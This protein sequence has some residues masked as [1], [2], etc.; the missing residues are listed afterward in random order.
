MLHQRGG[1]IQVIVDCPENLIVDSDRLRLKQTILN[2]GRNSAKFVEEGF[3]RLRALVVD[4]HVQL[5]VEDSGCGIPQEKRGRLFQKYQ[6]SLDLLSQ[7]TVREDC[8][9]V[10]FV[11]S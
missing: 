7:G 4:D 10:E 2:L 8:S 5:Y 6:E 11:L 3:I 1:K 9:S